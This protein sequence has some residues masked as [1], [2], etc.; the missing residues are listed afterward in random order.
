MNGRTLTW[1]YDGIYRLTNETVSA[2]PANKDG[3]VAYR[4]DPVG[5][6]L[7]ENSTLNGV[8]SGSLRLQRR[9]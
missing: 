4:L 1:S 3:D 7:S 8:Y 2:D 9:R 6:R 5:N